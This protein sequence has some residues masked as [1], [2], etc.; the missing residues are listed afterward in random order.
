M[1]N[2]N[3]PTHSY[4]FI[5]VSK[6]GYCPLSFTYIT[7]PSGGRERE[8][9]RDLQREDTER[10]RNYA[11][12]KSFFL[13]GQPTIHILLFKRFPIILSVPIKIVW[14]PIDLS[15]SPLW[16]VFTGEIIHKKMAIFPIAMF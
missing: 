9:E 6:H 8:R 2:K 13:P 1:E 3:Q 11:S 10:R 15:L 14:N 12:P 4:D 7:N 16:E 5:E